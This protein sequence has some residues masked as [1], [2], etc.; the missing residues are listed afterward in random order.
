MIEVETPGSPESQTIH[1]SELCRLIGMLESQYYLEV[2]QLRA[3]KTQ[4]GRIPVAAALTWLEQ[5]VAKYSKR[6]EAVERLREWQR[7]HDASGAE[8]ASGKEDA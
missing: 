6:V 5:R 8:F 3:P 4:R 7:R 2:K 1:I